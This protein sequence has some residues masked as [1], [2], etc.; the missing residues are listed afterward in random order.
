M[1]G[2]FYCPYMRNPYIILFISLG[3]SAITLWL[4]EFIVFGHFTEWT[5]QHT[6]NRLTYHIPLIDA[7]L[8][9]FFPLIT[10]ISL[11]MIDKNT[12]VK[13]LL[14]TI[15]ITFI[16]IV[17]LLLAGF[18]ITIYSW[19]QGFGMKS[20]VQPFDHYWTVLILTGIILPILFVGLRRKRTKNDDEIIDKL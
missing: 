11:F 9:R 5:M 6:G 19:P 7:Y 12:S 18:F 15:G 2:L 8:F 1:S 4:T 10:G 16:A 13:K 17:S 20:R 3:M 14:L